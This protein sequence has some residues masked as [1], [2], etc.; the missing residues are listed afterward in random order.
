M[1]LPS[2]WIEMP[3]GKALFQNSFR[4]KF[5]SSLFTFLFLVITGI[6]YFL[7]TLPTSS[8]DNVCLILYNCFTVTQMRQVFGSWVS[9][10]LDSCLVWQPKE[11][12]QACPRGIQTVLNY[13]LRDLFKALIRGVIFGGTAKEQGLCVSVCVCL[14]MHT[15]P[16]VFCNTKTSM[17]IK[18]HQLLPVDSP[19]CRMWVFVCE[20][21]LIHVGFYGLWNE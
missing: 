17:T 6:N 2:C 16:V 9:V 18:C 20:V 3:C 15:C 7:S 1:S 19:L 21:K 8:M 4:Y 11:L 10:R 12:P 14:H 5:A 13:I